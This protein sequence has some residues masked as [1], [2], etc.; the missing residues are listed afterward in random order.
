MSLLEISTLKD[1]RIHMVGIGGASMS[2]LA[3][4]LVRD[5]FTVSGSDSAD[6]YAI[7]RLLSLGIEIKIGHH[8]E[9][10]KGAGL[11]VY[12]AAIAPTDPERE[13]AA[14]KNI[15]QMERAVLLGQ[16]M[17]KSHEQLC[18]AGTHGKTTTSSMIAQILA[19]TGRDPTVHLG[20]S[21]DAIGGSVRIGDKDLFVAEACEFNRSFHHMPVSFAVLLN[22]EEDHLD[23]YGTM[24]KV[25]EAYLIFL[26]QLPENGLVLA[27]G[28][29]ERIRRVLSNLTP[30]DRKVLTFGEDDEDYTLSELEYNEKGNPSFTVRYRGE[31]LG[32]AQLSVPGYYNALHAL[33]ALAAAH[34]LNVPFDEAAASLSRFTGAHRRFEH[35][36]TV[37]GMD[38]YHDYGHNPAEMRV[39]I[40]MAKLQNR[41]V[42]AVMQPHT[43]SRVKTLFNEYLT[44]TKKAD[45]TLVTDIFAAREVDPGDISTPMLVEGMRKHGVNAFHTPDFDSTEAWIL[46]NGKKND[47]IITM[48]CGNINLLNE[49][50]QRNAKESPV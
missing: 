19:E 29:D 46:I 6:G 38:L 13:E 9:M 17:K 5:G 37:R 20:G 36:G 23:C 11:L 10:V 7:K 24:D 43:F 21:L 3:E 2:G 45:I 14:K 50:M 33:A 18:V 27:L 42:I 48:G 34:Q 41:R 28:K 15:P 8:P 32:Q 16:L 12:S 40:D 39:A 25:E 26:E 30:K 47:L 31:G 49:Q 22:I 35:T 44:C 4:M 1:R